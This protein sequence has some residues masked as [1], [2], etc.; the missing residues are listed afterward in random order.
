VVKA[1]ID[2]LKKLRTSSDVER[3]RGVTLT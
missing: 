3:L 2:A 1:T